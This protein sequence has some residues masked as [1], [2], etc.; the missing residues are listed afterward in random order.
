LKEASEA[1]KAAEESATATEEQAADNKY[2]YLEPEHKTGNKGTGLFIVGLILILAA[3]TILGVT[4]VIGS[5]NR[6]HEGSSASSSVISSI[7]YTQEQVD[8]MVSEASRI[9]GE[10]AKGELLT[11]IQTATTYDGGTLNL[12]KSLFPDSVVFADGSHYVYVPVDYNI[13]GNNLVRERFAKDETTGYLTYSDENGNVT[14]YIGIDVSRHQGN[15][16]WER[17]KAAGVDFVIIKC[18]IRGYG[19]EGNFAEDAMFR[20]NIEGALAAG[21]EVGVYFLTQA[22]TI[23]EAVEEAEWVLE[24]IKDYDMHGPIALDVEYAAADERTKDLTPDERST[25]ISYFCETVKEAGYTPL[26]YSN[27]KWFIRKMNM[28]MLDGYGKWYANYNS[29]NRA[30]GKT[31]WEFNDPLYFPYKVDM[32]QYTAYGT[33]DGIDGQTDINILFEKWW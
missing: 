9:S 23:D 6:I 7:T 1:A 12:L 17:V 22:V 14:S 11:T 18:G 3:V 4:L 13:E 29:L 24:M 33:I 31:V 21:L 16:D 19:P 26:I 27:T 28:S 32:W 8:E 20:T 30:D 25:N 15:I 2:A 10:E 5:R